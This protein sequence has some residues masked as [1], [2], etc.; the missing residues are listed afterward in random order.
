M[1]KVVLP[2][3]GSKE[4]RGDCLKSLSQRGL[5]YKK[6]LWEEKGGIQRHKGKEFMH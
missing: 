2:K 1:T 6:L 3:K 4:D 5:G